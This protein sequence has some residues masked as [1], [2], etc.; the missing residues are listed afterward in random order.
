MLHNDAE[1]DADQRGSDPQD[2]HAAADF[3]HNF[4]GDMRNGER[5]RCDPHGLRHAGCYQCRYR[6]GHDRRIMHD[7]NG[8]HLH[9]KNHGSQR[10]PEQCRETRCHTAHRHNSFFFFIQLP[11]AAKAGCKATAQLQRSPFSPG[12]ATQKMGHHCTEKD[13]RRCFDGHRFVGTNGYKNKV[14]PSVLFHTCKTIGQN[15][16]QTAQRQKPQNHGMFHAEFCRPFQHQMEGDPYQTDHKTD[17]DPGTH[18]CDKMQEIILT[19]IKFIL[20][21]IVKLSDHR[22][23]LPII[24]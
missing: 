2:H 16:G 14:R 22:T 18:P 24:T 5:C 4:F 3:H 12:R 10:R 23:L 7:T 11:H 8:D 13:Q 20:I 1:Q 21:F 15:D 19:S 17:G 9:G 6:T